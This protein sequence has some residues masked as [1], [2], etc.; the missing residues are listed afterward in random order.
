[1]KGQAW[2]DG[3]MTL[4]ALEQLVEALTGECSNQQRRLL[5]QR[6][7]QGARRLVTTTVARSETLDKIHK[8]ID[9]LE[10]L[11][12]SMQ[13]YDH[14]ARK[15]AWAMRKLQAQ[16]P[17]LLAEVNADEGAAAFSSV[18]VPLAGT[19]YSARVSARRV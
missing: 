1:M 6:L 5:A 17:T 12:T 14:Q 2:D 7:V 8:L 9:E 13:R 11:P 3:G 10:C 18:S 19:E 16:R 15:L 4:L